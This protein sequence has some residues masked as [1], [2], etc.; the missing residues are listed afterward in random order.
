MTLSVIIIAEKITTIHDILKQL[1][2]I[3]AR[4]RELGDS[5]RLSSNY[6]DGLAQ[7]NTTNQI[8][9]ERVLQKW[10][11]LDSQDSLVNWMTIIDVVKGPLVENKALAMKMYQDLKQ[12]ASKQQSTI[13]IIFSPLYISIMSF[14]QVTVKISNIKKTPRLVHR[15]LVSP[16]I[17]TNML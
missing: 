14:S 5:L 13:Y 10:I 6:L 15:K 12:E 17:T 7:S 3:D 1:I 11:E 2:P 4:W 9:L 16:L 8:R